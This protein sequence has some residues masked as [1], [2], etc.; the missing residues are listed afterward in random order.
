MEAQAN[1]KY[2]YVALRICKNNDVEKDSEML[3]LICEDLTTQ[4]IK[5]CDKLKYK[6][7]YGLIEIT[8]MLQWDQVTNEY[9]DEQLI[10]AQFIERYIMNEKDKL[11]QKE[12]AKMA[13]KQEQKEKPSDN[14]KTSNKKSDEFNPYCFSI[15][16][17]IELE[18][19]VPFTGTGGDQSVGL[20]PTKDLI[21]ILRDPN[22]PDLRPICKRI[23][24]C[25]VNRYVFASIMEK[26]KRF[27][28]KNRKYQLLNPDHNV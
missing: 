12:E 4:Q 16:Q 13:K 18:E 8:D 3:D 28:V 6:M 14:K 23:V 11:R 5:Q 22:V 24:T 27:L 7:H 25:A 9:K 10:Q 21:K 1:D 20:C 26:Q 17:V 19:G 15:G 2:V